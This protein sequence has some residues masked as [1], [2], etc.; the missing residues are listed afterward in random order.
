MGTSSNELCN[1]REINNCKN[2]SKG[3]IFNSLMEEKQQQ[4]SKE[5]S[6]IENIW[7]R[8]GQPNDEPIWEEGENS[9]NTIKV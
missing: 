2:E 3:N 4:A 5:I 9:A 6:K 1:K 7:E 8:N